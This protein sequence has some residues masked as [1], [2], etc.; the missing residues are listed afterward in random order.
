[1][2]TQ[3]RNRHPSRTTVDDVVFAITLSIFAAS[4]TVLVASALTDGPTPRTL[5]ASAQQSSPP[6]GTC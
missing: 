4:L 3:D 1:M 5:A 6:A 2:Q